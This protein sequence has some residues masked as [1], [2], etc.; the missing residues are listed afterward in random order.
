[1]IIKVKNENINTMMDYVKQEPSINLFIIG[2]VEQ[3]GLDVDFQE[4]YLQYDDNLITACVLRYYGNVVVYSHTDTFDVL[5]ILDLLN[6]FTYQRMSGKKQVIDILLPHL[7]NVNKVDECYFC[8]LSG[9]NN[10]IKPIVEVKNAKEEDV[11]R[12]YPL[13]VMAEFNSD[14][15]IESNQR[16]IK[17]K[18]GRIYFVDD[19]N[20]V[21]SSAATAIET[22]VSAMIGGVATHVDYRNKGLASQVVSKLCWDLLN[23]NKLPCLFFFNP[24]AGKIYHRLGFVDIDMWSMVAF[25]S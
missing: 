2:D 1:M 12:I 9:K 21:I 13:M 14:T 7:Q 17:E 8:E 24:F 11:E 22:S 3:F 19:G 16:K 15:Y 18:A 4:V 20:L 10:L 25:E 5:E 6:K 23:E